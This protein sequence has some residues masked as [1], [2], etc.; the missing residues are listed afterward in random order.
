[1]HVD[2]WILNSI[3]LGHRSLSQLNLNKARIEGS[4]SQATSRSIIKERS[5]IL[6]KNLNFRSLNWSIKSSSLEAKRSSE[7]T[8]I[9][10][11]Y[12]L[13]CW[14]VKISWKKIKWWKFKVEGANQ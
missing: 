14:A 8:C 13:R 7:I 10:Q 2:E 3:F 6:R 4:R 1:M 5:R 11:E 9:L 12:L